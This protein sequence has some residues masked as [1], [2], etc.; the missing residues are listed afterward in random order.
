MMMTTTKTTK[1][2]AKPAPTP[3]QREALRESIHDVETS[4]NCALIVWG[5]TNPDVRRVLLAFRGD[6]REAL[7]EART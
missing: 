5:K 3:A 2:A 1:A 7:G 4:V 6:L